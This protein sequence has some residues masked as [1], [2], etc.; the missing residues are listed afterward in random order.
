MDIY[1]E[2]CDDLVQSEAH[3][4]SQRVYLGEVETDTLKGLS[5]SEVITRT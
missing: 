1:Y 2:V 4:A 5:L 3:T